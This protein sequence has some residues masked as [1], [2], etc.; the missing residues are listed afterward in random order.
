MRRERCGSENGSGTSR[1]ALI[2]IIDSEERGRLKTKAGAE[3]RRSTLAG[4]AQRKQKGPHFA[5]CSQVAEGR[6]EVLILGSKQP[7]EKG[8]RTGRKYGEST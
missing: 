6:G 4:Y 1:V 7:V 5:S 3:R 8:V 2:L